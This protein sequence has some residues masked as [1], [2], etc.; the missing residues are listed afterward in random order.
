M[1]VLII[2]H[3]V[4]TESSNG[5][6]VL[7]N[8]FSGFDAEFAQIYCSSGIPNNKLCKNY[9]QITDKMIIKGLLKR[10]KI[11]KQIK[12]DEFPYQSTVIAT[13]NENQ[14]WYFKIFT[15]YRWSLFSLLRE[16]LWKLSSWKT[17]ELEKFILDFKPDIIFAPC[18]SHMFMLRLDRYVKKTAKVNMISYISDDNYSLR[19]FNL[20]PF[21]WLNRFLSRG[22][23]RKTFKDYSLVYTMTDEQANELNKSL[24]ANMKI[25]LKGDDFSGESKKLLVNNPIRI[26][27][28]GGIYVN[29]WKILSKI[30]EVLKE[31]NE[32]GV[33]IRL[34]IY[35]QNTCSQRQK[36]VLHDGRSIFLQ[37]AV[38]QN[39]L[40]KIYKLSDIALHVESFELKYRLLTRLSFSTKIVDCLAST[41]AVIA[42]SW[43]GHAGL[44]YLMQN[45]AALCIDDISKLKETLIGLVQKPDT[46][47]EYANKA[48]LCGKRNHQIDKIS[49]DLQS[50]FLRFKTDN[51]FFLNG[52]K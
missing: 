7:S 49:K 22:S 24:L 5:G 17:Y 15:R 21:Y 29:R 18:Y 47:V 28:A 20:S 9:F 30:G 50:D 11:G 51:R 42:I 6:N 48:W 44:K 12:F 2:S 26:V 1:R 13:N 4:W 45:D 43:K 32:D 37:A 31:I 41:C 36:N 23:I 25:L 38:G 35:T 40:K 8:I 10:Q 34:D 52:E 27:Y 16:F 19:Q 46:V 3:E 39:E 14:K 33:K